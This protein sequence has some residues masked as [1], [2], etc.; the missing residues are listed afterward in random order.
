MADQ[1]TVQLPRDEFTTAR[2][3]LRD[4][5]GAFG[6]GSTVYVTDDYG[7]L[8]T[9]VIETFRADGK[10]THL[11]QRN[12]DRWV[13]PPQV[14]ATLEGHRDRCTTQSRRRAARQAVQTRLDRGDVLGN[15]DALK[16]A[17]QAPRK[18]KARRGRKGAK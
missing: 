11:L 14:A 8:V 18:A 16:A 5:P 17:R 3:A 2:R 1:P 10:T 12:G 6:C 13:L 7:N 9:W 4:N 15:P